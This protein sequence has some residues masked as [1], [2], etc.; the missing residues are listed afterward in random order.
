M[1]EAGVIVAALNRWSIHFWQKHGKST[2]LW[3]RRNARGR[4]RLLRVAHAPL[5]GMLSRRCD[6]ESCLRL[7]GPR[8]VLPSDT[9]RVAV[10][11]QL[12][13]RVSAHV[14]VVATHQEQRTGA[15]RERLVCRTTA[16]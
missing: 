16:D 13:R 1:P 8:S 15:D 2:Y 11:G 14:A 7:F 4:R 12:P 3:P 10:C 9:A 6:R 5:G